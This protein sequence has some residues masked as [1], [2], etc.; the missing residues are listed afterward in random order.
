[1]FYQK[2][3]TVIRIELQRQF[4]YR[5]DIAMF[6]PGNL[7]ELFFSFLLWTVIFQTADVVRGYTYQDMVS[8]IVIGWICMFIT[9]NYGFEENVS[10]DIRLGHLTNYLLRPVSYLKYVSTV[11]VGRVIIAFGFVILQSVLYV[12]IFGSRMIIDLNLQKILILAVMLFFAF[13]IK[14]FISIIIGM[15]SFW[16]MYVNGLMTFSN[17][18]MKLFSGAYFP[19]AILPVIFLKASLF[20][21]FAYT[22]FIP[23]QFFLG[24][25]S[26]S[27]AI[28][29][30]GVQVIW[31]IALYFIAKIIY[32]IG[33]KKYESVG[34]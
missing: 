29:G 30:I 15:V 22:F 32:K 31:L 19:L 7:F 21:P 10:R 23:V 16:M 18:L 2:Y 1:M 9:N 14:L 5:Y 28:R 34:A 24:K 33:L 3:L 12:S 8:Y 4:T 11:A 25:I 17:T 6:V 26:Y 13:F 27:D 20:L